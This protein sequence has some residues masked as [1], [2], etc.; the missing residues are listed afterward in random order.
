MTVGPPVLGVGGAVAAVALAGPLGLGVAAVAAIAITAVF[1]GVMGGVVLTGVANR[2]PGFSSSLKKARIEEAREVARRGDTP[3]NMRIQRDQY[4]QSLRTRGKL[5][6]QPK[7]TGE[8]PLL[9]KWRDGQDG[10]LKQCRTLGGR[11]SRKSSYHSPSTS[12]TR[13]LHE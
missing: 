7:R 9:T 12:R 10:V 2:L 6:Q 13:P 5:L 8:I 1:V 4:I 3:K 11:Q